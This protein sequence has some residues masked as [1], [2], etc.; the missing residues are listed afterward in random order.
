MPVF[1]CQGKVGRTKPD[2]CSVSNVG[3]RAVRV[4]E[5]TGLGLFVV[6]SWMGF[7]VRAGRLTAKLPSLGSNRVLMN[8]KMMVALQGVV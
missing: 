7:A 5:T 8:P 4:K 2:D 6:C 3:I 1:L